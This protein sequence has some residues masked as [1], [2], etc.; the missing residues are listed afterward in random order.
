VVTPP[1]QDVPEELGF[2]LLGVFVAPVAEEAFFRGM[3]FGGLRR[4]MSAIPAA[5][6]SGVVFGAVHFASGA[7]A[8]P[9]LAILGFALCLLY[10]RTG[11]LLPGLG[12]HTLNNA[13]ATVYILSSS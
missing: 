8:I 5:A 12:A 6:I 3:L 1:D 11:S 2:L 13:L 7:A 9:P 4:G 10:E